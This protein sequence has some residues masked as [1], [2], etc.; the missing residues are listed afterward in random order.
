[1]ISLAVVS[2]QWFIWGFSLAFSPNGGAF[3]G[4][5]DNAFFMGMFDTPNYFYPLAK[6][7][8]GS[9]FALFQG[10]FACIT[11]ALAFGGAAERI[12]II[13]AI[14]FLFLWSTI[15][16][17]VIAYWTWAPNGWMFKMGSYD[18]AGGT[19]V[20]ISSGAAGAAYAIM[21]GKRHGYGLGH[22]K[23]HNLS[24]V[25]LG[26]AL[27]WFGWIGFNGGS[28]LAADA[29]ASIAVLNTNLAAATGGLTWLAM[30]Y[31]LEKKFSAFAFC[32]GTV[33]GLVNITPAAG[34]VAPWAAFIMAV[35][36]TIACNLFVSFKH[37]FGF[38]DA[39]DVFGVHGV[40]GFVGNL[41]T[42]IFASKQIAAIGGVTIEGGWIDGHWVQLGYQLAGSLAAVAWSFCLTIIILFVLDK[43]PYLGLRLT[44]DE[45]ILGADRAQMGDSA[46]DYIEA[47]V[48]VN[49]SIPREPKFHRSESQMELKELVNK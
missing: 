35:I 23:P 48:N 4:T 12:R 27:L 14:V 32:S 21:A 30:E 8:P 33:A 5:L 22:F 18:F 3:I 9:T 49:N 26:T 42:G 16:Y 6:T 46:Y 11:P 31:R 25:F 34:F 43:L 38:D 41:L 15:V 40:G 44:V 45:E 7:I 29:R 37:V 13:P 36:G 17:N 39:L 10:M 2:I 1:M 24:S 20:H 19:P 28:Q 47:S